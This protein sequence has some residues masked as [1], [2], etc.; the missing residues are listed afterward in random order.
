[1]GDTGGAR[2][3]RSKDRF[4][5]LHSESEIACGGVPVEKLAVYGILEPE[6][7]GADGDAIG[8]EPND[9]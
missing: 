2:I 6:R 4:V 5:Q 9:T 8:T 7:A 1:M 3:P